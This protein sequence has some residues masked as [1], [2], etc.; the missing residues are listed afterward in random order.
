M[1]S[2]PGGIIASVDRAGQPTYNADTGGT[3]RQ[4]KGFL[5]LIC[6]CFGSKP[7][8]DPPSSSGQNSAPRTP[9]T[10]EGKALLP[11][12]SSSQ[13][14]YKK[15]LV[16]D[17]DETLVHSSFKPID[18][19][20]FI[21]PVEIESVMHYVY[22]LKRPG[23]DEFLEKM[24]E[25]FE[26][27]VFTASLQ[28]YADPLLDLLDTRKVVAYRLFREACVNFNGQLVKDLS[29]LGRDLRHTII[30][31]NSPTSYM[32]HVQNAMP[33]RSWFDD[34]D[35]REL[36]AVSPIL[37]ECAESDNVVVVLDRHSQE[38]I[39]RADALDGDD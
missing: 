5:S 3:P 36:A 35:D 9:A 39:N 21:V 13:P 17:L 20:D 12:V 23:V 18:R 7:Y 38:L 37:V 14:G 30:V 16:L 10:H 29:K 33:I 8:A 27:V 32:L 11:P 28:K 4:K 31:D 25:L 26:I 15:C 1:M 2:A 22:V 24:A 6:P 19:P 34:P